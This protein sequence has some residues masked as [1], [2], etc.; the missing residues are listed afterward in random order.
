MGPHRRPPPGRR[1]P[2]PQP[3]LP[4]HADR[5]TPPGSNSENGHLLAS[6]VKTFLAKEP[7]RSAAECESAV[8]ARTAINTYSLL[9]AALEQD[10]LPRFSLGVLS[11]GFKSVLELTSNSSSK[12]ALADGIQETI[13]ALHTADHQL[14]FQ[15]S[16][17]ADMFDL[18]L[19]A[20]IKKGVLYATPFTIY[21][22]SL[23]SK[24]SVLPFAS[25]TPEV[26]T[27]AQT[28]KD[29]TNHTAVGNDTKQIMANHELFTGGR[30][31]NTS[32]VQRLLTNVLT[33]LIYISTDAPKSE[34]YK[35]PSRFH[36]N[37]PGPRELRALAHR[38]G[39][40]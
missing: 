18:P 37:S 5:V 24:L 15:V 1:P 33:F 27:R 21:P 29:A 4:N 34:L 28:D 36:E 6:V 11:E 31:H 12:T 9:P 13:D 20:I 35:K 3:Y 19:T 10:P 22:G 23:K 8:Q 25:P 32:E 17:N 14:A 7:P 30:L 40:T 38:Q 16:L 39:A 26:P 2:N